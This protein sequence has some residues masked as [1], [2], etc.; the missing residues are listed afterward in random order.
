MA[1]TREEILLDLSIKG[2]TELVKLRGE[3]DKTER[4]L[5]ALKS[6]SKKNKE[7]TDRQVQGLDHLERKL[8]SQRQQYRGAQKALQG[9]NQT[10]KRGTSFTM[11]MAKAFSVAQI[12]TDLFTKAMRAIGQAVKQAVVTFKDFEFQMA[13]VKAISGASEKEF[14]RLIAS[15]KQLGRTTFFTASQVGEL[16][17]NLSKLGF[18][19]QEILN[20]QEA[21]LKLSTAMGEDLGRTATV[22]AATIRGFGEDTD[23]TARFADVMASAF[24]NSALDIEKFQTSMSKVSAIASMAGFSFEETTGLLALLTDRGIE[25]SIAGTSLRNILLHLQD[26]SSDLSQKLGRTVHS[27]EDFIV[28][29]KELK[30]SGIDVAGVMEIVDRRQVQAMNSFIASADSLTDFNNLMDAASGSGERMAGIM[31]KTVGG[32]LLKLKSAYEGFVLAVTTGTGEFSQ[33]IQKQVSAISD[34]LN[35]FADNLLSVGDK[36]TTRVIKLQADAQKIIQDRPELKLSDALK[37]ES[38]ILEGEIMIFEKTLKEMDNRIFK[39]FLTGH[40]KNKERLQKD[41]DAGRNALKEIEKIIDDQIQKETEAAN[42][43]VDNDKK[44]EK[45]SNTLTAQLE[46]LKQRQKELV[47]IGSNLT[48]KGREELT[49]TNQKIKATQDE[50]KAL[51]ELGV[52]KQKKEPTQI[53]KDILQAEFDLRESLLSAQD[54]FNAREIKTKEELN[55]VMAEMT[56]SHLNILL[57]NE[58]LT[59]DQRIAIKERVAKAEMTITNQQIK[60]EK[61]KKDALL[62]NINTMKETGNVLMNIGQ[63]TGKNSLAAKAGIKISQAAAIADGV[64][65]LINAKVGIAAQAKLPFPSNIL[66]MASTAAQVASIVVAIKQLLGGAGGSGGGAGDVERASTNAEGTA[67]FARGGLTRGGV[68]QGASHANGGVKFAVGGR[69]ME[70]EG[71]EAIINKKS[72]SAFRPILSAI[73]SFNGN[74]VKF[75]DGGLISSGERFA[76]GGELRSIQN[77]VS[78]NSGTSQVIVVESE[79]TTTQNRVSALESQ[80]SF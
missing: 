17:L 25:A 64:H 42:Q 56:I 69:V 6:Q 45:A 23:Q 13:K 21:I 74:G 57:E 33:F 16:Q 2:T 40:K 4:S 65:G 78:N 9:L 61:D 18:N 1:K 73:N 28:A 67:T 49:L 10:Q 24:A 7:T 27:G 68:F 31:E 58:N 41:I 50:I 32:S 71:G 5:K 8:K 14:K 52:E 44:T 62:E 51:Q 53:E 80:A 22:V 43:K 75:A 26:G 63:I 38:Q 48:Q 72:T 70:A 19:P 60:S 66:A 3:I 35:A 47:D 15:A 77:I 11:K 29:L 37:M 46:K 30:A 12:A 36:T 76:L 34:R 20:A 79:V 54:G 39:G 59:A 55:R